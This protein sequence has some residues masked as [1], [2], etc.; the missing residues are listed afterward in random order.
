METLTAGNGPDIIFIDAVRQAAEH[1]GRVTSD[2]LW[3]KEFIFTED[4]D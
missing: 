3:E 1:G 4:P 2:Q